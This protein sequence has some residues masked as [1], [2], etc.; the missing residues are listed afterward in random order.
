[1]SR[2]SGL[3][4][5]ALLALSPLG[6]TTPQP[7]HDTDSG[8]RGDTGP[9]CSGAQ[10][11]CGGTCV[12]ATTDEM[13][14]G[15]CGNACPAMSTC[16][17]S[18]CLCDAGLSCL[19]A[20]GALFCADGQTDEMNCGTC[21]NACATGQAC[22]AGEC[23][24]GCS[25]ASDGDLVLTADMQLAAGTYDYDTITIP[26]GVTLSFTGDV[27]VIL[28]AR[29]VTIDGTIS[30][31]GGDG[32]D[33][34][35]VSLPN[36]GDAVGGGGGGGGGGSCGFG[37]MNGDGVPGMP[38]GGAPVHGDP[39]GQPN[40]SDGGAG[41]LAAGVDAS[42]TAAVGGLYGPGG[43]GGG[44]GASATGL[45]GSFGQVG[46][47]AFSDPAMTLLTGGG[48]GAGG[49]AN[50]GGGGGG[51]GAIRISADV[52]TLAAT[53]RISADGGDGG[54]KIDGDCTSGGGGGGG[55]GMIWLDASVSLALDGV[56]SA[57]GGQ[58]GMTDSVGGA[59]AEGRIQ[60]SAPSIETMT[61]AATPPAF[62]SFDL[63]VCP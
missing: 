30:L 22:V 23:R 34:A 43:G 57:V 50:G 40:A 3:I 59:G 11:A 48:G 20:S 53:G 10:L 15:A 49:G 35:M 46:G 52:I 21:G 42:A 39:M 54:T 33:S 26:A 37:V 41:G 63:P 16:T 19:N 47:S 13:N 62:R 25:D 8:P 28:R 7:L 56:L 45:S 17:A 4:L 6:C 12:D 36:G 51:G 31:D 1:M 32:A 44:G 38:N 14:C 61:I 29:T 2:L 55:G 60:V 58:G 9:S 24:R 27:P 5:I 18:H